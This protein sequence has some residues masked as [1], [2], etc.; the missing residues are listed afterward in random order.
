MGRQAKGSRLLATSR[1]AAV[2]GA[3][4]ALPVVA[5]AQDIT[6]HTIGDP[7]NEPWEDERYP[8]LK[9]NGRGRVDYRYRMSETELTVGQWVEFVRAYGPHAD[10]PFDPRLTG[11][12]I[13]GEYEDGELRYE[14]EPGFENFPAEMS[15]RMAARFCNWMHNG[16]AG[17][18]W[19]FEN[20][21]Y[22]TS[23][24]TRNDDGTY[25]DQATRSPGAT[26]WVP[27][28]DEWMKG[29][30]YDPDKDGPGL[31][32]WWEHP[33]SGDDPLIADYPENGGE[34][35][36]GLFD[37]SYGAY[38]H[39]GQYRHVTSP[40][41]LLD[42]SG[43]MREFTEECRDPLRLD[44]RHTKGSS[45]FD[46]IVPYEMDWIGSEWTIHPDDPLLVGFRVASAIPTAPTWAAVL[47]VTMLERRRRRS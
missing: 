17:E 43:G 35:N 39:V 31:G 29:M 7:V 40:W 26:Y 4:C 18:A 45:L 3:L 1:L 19:A 38:T 28:M 41:G 32:G 10:D 24:F 33:G 5:H 27:S 34:T 36:A 22:D 12:F 15:W 25:N 42:G 37:G 20:G 44:A 47:G 9:F 8:N 14:V 23:T 2:T 46:K 21:A 11:W 30:Y 6:W 13:S 16:R